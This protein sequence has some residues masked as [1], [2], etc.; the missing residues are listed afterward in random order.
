M[1]EIL[2]IGLVLFI[3][4][5]GIIAGYCLCI[6]MNKTDAAII[7]GNT[8][9][10]QIGKVFREQEFGE[11]E[12]NTIPVKVKRIVEIGGTKYEI[13]PIQYGTFSPEDE[14]QRI[15]KDL[16]KRDVL[17]AASEY[18]EYFDRSSGKLGHGFKATLLVLKEER[19]A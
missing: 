5:I 7:E 14:D 17:E 8:I 6:G 16:L 3:F 11:P 9:K 10:E 12:E 1:K 18:I 4:S 19:E 15:S 2:I 13:V